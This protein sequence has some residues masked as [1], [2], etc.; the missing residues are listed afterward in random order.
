MAEEI[1]IA[2]RDRLLMNVA[3]KQ[4][5]LL[6]FYVATVG[7][8]ILVYLYHQLLTD[9]LALRQQLG[10]TDEALGHYGGQEIMIFGAIAV[11][12]TGF[13]AISVSQHILPLLYHIEKVMG[14][15]AG[16]DLNQRVGFS[17][18]DE[19]GKIGSAI[20]TTINKLVGLIKL[21]D[22]S[23][24]LLL[25]EADNIQQNTDSTYQALDTQNHQLNQCSTAMEEMSC[26]I[27]ET[28]NNSQEAQELAVS[29]NQEAMKIQVSIEQTLNDIDALCQGI[30]LA[31]ESSQAL[32]NQLQQIAGTVEVIDGIS[33]QTNLLAL[34]T[35]IEAARAGESGRGFAVVA[36]EV[37]QLA[38]RSQEATDSIQGIIDAVNANSSALM[39]KM[40]AST[41][42][43]DETNSR[44]KESMQEIGGIITKIEQISDMNVRI[45]AAVQQQS[46]VANDISENI[47]QIKSLSDQ[48]SEQMRGLVDGNQE[49][50][51]TA[52]SLG[53][54]LQQFNSK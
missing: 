3:L 18:E 15:I 14:I 34:N 49:I 43:A 29:S 23:S 20:D 45:A 31:G 24:A 6:P 25:Q 32:E 7:I 51:R 37:R 5:M 44:V 46:T 36:D 16:G 35:A 30:Q 26:S 4:K 19:F 53:K 38:K 8:G 2:L 41:E 1:K 9:Y 27:R 21:V 28:A 11:V 33:A 50:R 10:T 40:Q 48:S 39:E 52:E 47:F 12:L 42:T 54:A 13:I 17:G 22:Q